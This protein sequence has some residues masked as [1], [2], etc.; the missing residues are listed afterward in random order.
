MKT[1]ALIAFALLAACLARADVNM[2]IAKDQAKRAAG[3]AGGQSP[4]GQP[5]AAPPQKP[6]DPALAAT[7]QNISNLRDDFNAISAAADPAAAAEQKVALL[8]NLTA[9]AQ[10]KK[11]SSDNVKKLGSQ[12]VN[13][14]AGHPKISAKSQSLARNVHALFNGAHLSDPQKE[15]L[16]KEAR[17][18]LTD[19][20]VSEEDAGK[21]EE[22]L[23]AVAA[24]TK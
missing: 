23:K 18:L 17:K 14:L 22:L 15:T 24:E 21:V 13:T 5:P 8:N 20:G 3:Q 11:A 19:A 7:L 4:P 10:G 16:L 2:S 12:F 1:P 9:A 6:M